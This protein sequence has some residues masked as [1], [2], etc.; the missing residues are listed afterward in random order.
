MKKELFNYFLKKVMLKEQELLNIQ[1]EQA[2]LL[3]VI[4]S[5]TSIFR[6]Y[7]SGC[8]M[9]HIYFAKPKYAEELFLLVCLNAEQHGDHLL[10]AFNFTEREEFHQGRRAVDVSDSELAD[11]LYKE[12]YPITEEVD[13][14]LYGLLTGETP[15]GALKTMSHVAPVYTRAVTQKKLEISEKCEETTMIDRAWERLQA[16]EEF[17]ELLQLNKKHDRQ[18]KSNAY[19]RYAPHLVYLLER[20]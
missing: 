9:E 3:A 6:R 14:D 16:D 19:K 18:G 10:R 4:F 17:M 1:G 11:Y 15:E 12:V 13:Y 8:A 7:Q 2:L 5:S 20:I